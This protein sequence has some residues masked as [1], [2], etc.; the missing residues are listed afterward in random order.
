MSNMMNNNLAM[1]WNDDIED[2]GRDFILLEEGDYNYVVRDFERGHFPGSAK[3]PACNKATLTLEV[4]T[5]EG[6]AF[7]KTDLILCRTLEFR[8]SSFFRSIGQKK[9]GERLV[10]NWNKVVGAQ[11][12]AHF[13]PRPYTTREGEQKMAND[14]ERFLDY[15]PAFFPKQQTPAWVSEAANAPQ[16]SWKQGS[17]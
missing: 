4:E 10:M 16:Q 11:G 7:V 12:R 15:D 17:F 9:H 3:L 5:R 14:V 2:D 13:K 8:I 1:D 6:S